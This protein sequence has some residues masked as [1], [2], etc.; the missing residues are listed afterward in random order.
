MST[1]L[2]K[3]M[4]ITGALS[5]AMAVPALA[6]PAHVQKTPE[7]V[8]V[9]HQ[10]PAKQKVV[11]HVQVT[12]NSHAKNTRGKTTHA[13]NARGKTVYVSQAHNAPRYD[14]RHAPQRV[15]VTKTVVRHDPLINHVVKTATREI[16][17]EIIRH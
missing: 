15:V 13:H 12:H 3:T 9:V 1:K 16:V 5:M 14:S 4:A 6:A 10:T 2:I 7:K 17:R 8:V 11:K